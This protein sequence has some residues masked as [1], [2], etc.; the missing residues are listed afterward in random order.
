MQVQVTTDNHVEGSDRLSAYVDSV[1]RDTL[2]RF[3]NRVTRVEV[4]LGDENSHKSGLDK[5]CAM[6]ARLAGMPPVT[7]NAQA[8]S[9]DQAI[10][11]A[12]D[13]LLKA[14]D[15]QTGRKDDHKGRTSMSGDKGL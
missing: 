8:G 11:G 13:K 12:A 10:D 4:H 3:G 7:V 5:W 9:L 1:V 2:G 14:L 15:R 6:E